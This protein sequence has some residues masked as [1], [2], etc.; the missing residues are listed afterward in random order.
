MFYFF[1]ISV[2][3]VRPIISTSTELIFTKFAGSVELWPQINDVK[4]IFF[5]PSGDVAVA[6]NFVGKIDLYSMPCS[7]NDIR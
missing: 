6:T 3:S 5:D 7:S 1:N 2:I 4:L